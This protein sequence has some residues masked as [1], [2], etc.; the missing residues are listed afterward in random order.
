MNRGALNDAL[1]GSRWHG[2]RA[3]DVGFQRRQIVADEIF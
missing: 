3:V 1:K 2:F